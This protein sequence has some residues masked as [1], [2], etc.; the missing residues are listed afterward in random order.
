MVLCTGNLKYEHPLI[1]HNEFH[2]P[3]CGEI[4]DHSETQDKLYRAEDNGCSEC[5]MLQM[6]IDD[7]TTEIMDLEDQVTELELSQ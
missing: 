1:A 4:E 5:Q 3:L 6:E 7:L 2:C